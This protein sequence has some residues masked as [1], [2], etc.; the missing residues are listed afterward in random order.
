LLKEEIVKLPRLAYISLLFISLIVLSPRF[1]IADILDNWH[2]RNPLP[3]GNTLRGVAYG[4]ATFV[5]VG[6][7]ILTSS[8]GISWTEREPGTTVD[9]SGVAY[10]NGTFVV[11]R[12]GGTILQSNSLFDNLP[13]TPAP[14]IS[15]KPV[16]VNLGSEKVDGVSIP[17]TLTIKNRG[18]SDLVINSITISGTNASEFVYSPT[19]GC[20]N[21][22][23]TH[24]SCQI[25]VTFTPA[26]PF[27]KKSS[28]IS[29]SSND[30]KKPI[31]NVKLSGRAPP[32]KISVARK[33]VNFAS[34]VGYISVPKIITIKNRGKS[35]LLVNNIAI[36]GTNGDD[37][38]ETNNCSPLAKGSSCIINITFN[39]TSVGR[40][41]AAL[42]ILSNDPRKPSVNVELSG[43]ASPSPTPTLVTISVTP[44]NQSISVGGYLYFAAAGT[45]S[46]GTIHD[47]TAQVAWISS[48]TSVATVNSSGLA[49]GVAVGTANITATSGSIAG[50]TNL[51]VIS[52][53]TGEL[54]VL[55]GLTE[56]VSVFDASSSGNISP[57]RKFGNLTGLY[58]PHGIAVDT[59]NNEIF[60]TNFAYPDRS[61]ITVY[62]RTAN[63]NASPV[64][65]ISGNLTGLNAPNGIAVDTANNEIFVANYLS[66]SINVYTR[67][68]KGNTAP[69]RTISGLGGPISVAVDTI[70][71]EIFVANLDSNTIAVYAR[72]A[73]GNATPIRTF[74]TLGTPTD[75]IAVDTVNNEIFVNANSITAVYTRTAN[76]IAIPLRIIA[77]SSTGISSSTGIAVDTI[78]NEIFVTNSFPP[79]SLPPSITV[80][81][82]TANGNVAPLRTI[83]IGGNSAG[84]L[85]LDITNNELLVPIRGRSVVDVY[86]RTASGDSTPLRT[87]SG[88]SEGID[89]LNSIAADTMHNEILI[90]NVSGCCNSSITVYAKTAN[91]DVPPLRI[92]SG[93]STG[94]YY[95]ESIAVDTVNSEI[96]VGNG[97]SISVYTR[98]ANGDVPALRT[99]S[100]IFTLLTNPQGIAVDT[101][102]NEILVTDGYGDN[103]SVNV[104]ARSINGDK[105]PVRRIFGD[106]TGLNSPWGIALDN[107]HNEIFVV[108]SGNNSITVYARTADGNAIP[109]RTISG[110]STGLSEPNGIAVSSNEIFVSNFDN[111]SITVYSLTA[112]G[113]VAPLRVV[114]DSTDLVGPLGLALAPQ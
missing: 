31:V 71:N 38:T 12:A 47:I 67:T 16:P 29:I 109:L 98:T 40:K 66:N 110:P 4:N 82:R 57:E 69:L 94:L 76:G 84:G 79:H 77:G 21:P 6:A 107:I 80:Y 10:A 39:P 108:N 100:G 87:I 111:D 48:N 20:P 114:S 88:K 5:A 13:S 112:D 28:T 25:T 73:S 54:F 49:T 46:D 1:V 59:V 72:T 32:P 97:E 17:R 90:T 93:P 75:A 102:N 50:S 85:A 89:S 22:I 81:S 27:G 91:G 55:N 36:T 44:A 113:D 18:K 104:Y 41:F 30:P 53:T 45:Y 105:S 96:F 58:D 74:A 83:T 23:P 3:Q 33:A 2:W 7:A 60:I 78:N 15:V 63:G 64:R 92:I 61:S 8:D 43:N 99:V 14:K 37:F 9:L 56:N 35:D 95:P 101:V 52:S 62:T 34:N 68:A 51:S 106:S 65:T 24:G 19:S 86:E 11:V 26:T 103:A 42:N 70:N